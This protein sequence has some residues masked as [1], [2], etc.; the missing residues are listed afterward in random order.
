MTD[1][2][3]VTHSLP[4]YGMFEMNRI[5]HGDHQVLGV[6]CGGAPSR[7]NALV[8][9]MSSDSISAVAFGVAIWEPTSSI[10]HNSLQISVSMSALHKKLRKCEQ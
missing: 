10:A 5:G 1:I 4:D 3:S 8:R 7:F 6:P 9:R 2:L